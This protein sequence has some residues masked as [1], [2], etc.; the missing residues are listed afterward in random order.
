MSIR[1]I[2]F[3]VF[4]AYVVYRSFKSGPINL[5]CLLVFIY[6]T[7]PEMYIW[8]IKEYRVVF[9]LNIV[10]LLCVLYTQGKLNIFGDKY[11]IVIICFVFSVFISALFAKVNTNIAM[12]YAGLFFKLLIFWVLLKNILN[13]I[14]KIELF[15]WVC[16][17]S[18]TFLAGWGVQQYVLGNIRLE[19]FGGGQISGSN[20]LASALIWGVPIA[21]FNMLHSDGKKRKFAATSCLLILFAGIVCTESRQAFMAILFYAGYVFVNSKRKVVLTVTVFLVLLC[22]LSLVPE[23]YFD[24]METIQNYE[25]DTSAMGRIDIWKV[26]IRMWNDNPIIGV[27]GRNFFPM[28]ARYTS[29]VRVTHNTY[30][31]ILSE[32]GLLGIV[33]FCGLMALALFDLGKIIRK[34]KPPS[35]NEK[36]YCYA[37]IA[38]LSLMGTLICCFFQN[39]AEHEFLYWP[40]AI[41]AALAAI[42]QPAAA[43]TELV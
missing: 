33:F 2:L 8:G 43:E 14:T 41:T 11:S 5:L 12:N 28:A 24:R 10:L 13:D 6:F 30:F 21:Y 16:L 37:S 1:L 9:F 19:N 15:Y 32:E 25:D 20:Q 42:D 38:R 23:G 36:C 34:Y 18:L 35:V 17:A 3:F 22:S 40:V 26:A 7:Y 39:K 27:G 31:Q 29:H 4:A